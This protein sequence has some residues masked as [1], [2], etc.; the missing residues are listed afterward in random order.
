MKRRFLKPS[1]LDI[2]RANDKAQR[3]YAAMSGLDTADELLNNVA[4]K[5]TRK[6]SG[7]SLERDVLT[8]VSELLAVHPA[9]LFAV[10]QNSGALYYQRGDQR[11][12]KSVPVHFFKW[13]RRRTQMRLVDIWGA[14]TDGRLLAIELKKPSWGGPSDDRER[15]QRAFLECILTAGGRAGFA[16]SASEALGII[17]G[18]PGRSG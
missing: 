16:R 18:P 7:E 13:L 9:I 12:G 4:E 6:P 5:R 3:F 10:R 8:E 11:G 17:D 14:T 15:E 2:L 1:H